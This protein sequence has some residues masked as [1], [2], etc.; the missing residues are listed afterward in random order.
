[1][2]KAYLILL[3]A[4]I[5]FPACSETFSP[6]LAITPSLSEVPCTGGNVDIKVMTDLPWKVEAGE[7]CPASFSKTTGIGDDVVT[8]TIPATENWT[9]SCISVKFIARS[10]TYNSTRYAYITQ[11][12]KPYI[13]ISGESYTLPKEGGMATVV[14]TANT[15]WTSSSDTGGVTFSPASG[16]TGNTTVKVTVPAN[17][18]ATRRITVNFAIDGDSDHFYLYQY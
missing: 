7:D 16:S 3:A 8:V 2:K 13:S 18:G 6:S 15:D 10:N 9:T 4:A 12:Y 5:I 14:V 1:M 17:E 11:D